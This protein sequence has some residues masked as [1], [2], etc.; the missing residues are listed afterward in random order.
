MVFQCS[1]QLFFSRH[2]VHD[3]FRSTLRR[4]IET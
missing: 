2:L 3:Q 4:D 1:C